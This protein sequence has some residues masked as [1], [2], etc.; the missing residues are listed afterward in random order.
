MTTKLRKDGE[1]EER[2]QEFRAAHTFTLFLSKSVDEGGGGQKT[3]KT[4]DVIY[5]RPLTSTL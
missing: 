4:S 3:R 1:I 5:E 2:C